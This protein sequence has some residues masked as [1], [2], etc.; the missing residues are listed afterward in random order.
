MPKLGT[1]TLDELPC[2]HWRVTWT[3]AGSFLRN[4][5]AFFCSRAEAEAF[6][7]DRRLTISSDL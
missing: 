4:E 1:A 5:P 2:G 6:C 3:N 7:R